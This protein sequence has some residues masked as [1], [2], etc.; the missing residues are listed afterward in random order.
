MDR[1]FK[2]DHGCCHGSG[3][4]VAEGKQRR[5][6]RQASG[7]SVVEPRRDRS[8]DDDSSGRPEATMETGPHHLGAEAP[9]SEVP[10]GTS[11]LKR[12]SCSWLGF[13]SVPSTFSMSFE[14]VEQPIPLVER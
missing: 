7:G 5:P 6:E 2:M 8:N 11:L 9:L 13:I 3:S 4:V 12:L 10:R 14:V 1:H